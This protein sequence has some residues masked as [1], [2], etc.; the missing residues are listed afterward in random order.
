MFQHPRCLLAHDAG[1]HIADLPLMMISRH[2]QCPLAYVAE[3]S[4][5]DLLLAAYALVAYGKMA[6]FILF[7]YHSPTGLVGSEIHRWL[8][9]VKIFTMFNNHLAIY[10]RFT[11]IFNSWAAAIFYFLDRFSEKNH[12]ISNYMNSMCMQSLETNEKFSGI[13]EIRE[14][15][16]ATILEFMHRFGRLTNLPDRYSWYQLV[17]QISEELDNLVYL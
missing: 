8:L 2:Q 11:N 12:C 10:W 13:I 1:G 3:G 17:C 6:K 5:A 7:F 9:H 14:I 4:I 15:V 16:M